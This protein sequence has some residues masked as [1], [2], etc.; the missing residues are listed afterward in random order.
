[1]KA[2]R[3]LG[4]AC[5]CATL[6]AA[7]PPHTTIYGFT[8]ITSDKEFALEDRFLDIPTAS[9]AL[10][11]AAVLASRPHYAG[12]DGDYKLAYFVRDTFKDYGIEATVESFTAR[13]DT[14]KKLALEI[15]PPGIVG[16][17][18]PAK[19]TV[20]AYTPIFKRRQ[21]RDTANL[22][23]PRFATAP[24]AGLDL[25]ELP[26]PNDPDT[27]NPAVGLPF[28]AGSGDGDVTGPLVYAGHGLPADY[29]LLTAH[30]IDVTG[31]VVLV[32]FGAEF[33]G[34]IVR[35][36]QNH[37]VHAV[38][39]YDDP[40]DDGPGRGGAYPNGPWRP[41]NSVQRGSL[42]L[43]ITVPV[44]PIS[45]NNARLLLASI[46]GPSAPAP[47]TGRLPV[48]YPFAKGPANVR[49]VVELNHRT[50]TLWNTIGVIHGTTPGQQL[51][52]GAHRDAWVYGLGSG[53]GGVI[54]LLETARGL[55][56][57]ALTGWQPGR[58]IVLAAWD[59][60]E[61][62][63]FGSLA[64][65]KRH[66]DELN[67]GS[68]AY[69]NTEPSVT[70]TTFGADAVAAIAPTIAEASHVAPDPAFPG[71]TIYERWAFR[72]HGVL[73]PV[74]R[75]PG[76]GDRDA[77][78]FNAGTPSA[79]ASFTGP[80]GPYHSSY[81]TLLYARTI[82]DPEFA[83]HRAAAQIYGVAALRLANADVVPYH[84]TAYV[85]PMH[86]AVRS[87]AA[88]ARLR[89]VNFDAR[90][91]ERSIGGFA[92]SAARSDLATTR[93]SAAQVPE[94]QLE[95][96]RIIDLAAYGIEGDSQISFPDVEHAVR[97]GDQAG[98]DLAIARA[99]TT[100]DRASNLIH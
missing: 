83:L 66:G 71:N 3:V 31:S 64:Y 60:E 30:G 25:R 49:V 43:G 26:D 79:N 92:A 73:P 65:I 52:I 85:A 69:L 12:S 28:L 75:P 45:A 62:G 22:A 82:S 93:V 2:L 44:L 10:E 27:Q 88:L 33:R 8:T 74:T 80:F 96:A 55:G 17:A 95:A 41:L 84:F 6:L 42:G 54:T 21:K 86:S 14:P 57:L 61:L 9:G 48:G 29:A 76:G 35:R 56:N 87:L 32:R 15:Y 5:A 78:L 72:T 38:I 47:W 50:T 36:A 89:N 18:P 77:F 99:R 68:I 1:M 100:I 63:Q 90:G 4:V 11:N 7:A 24:M 98:V 94:N 34:A 59:G 40:A 13:I 51:V 67:T 19:I 70:G 46:H 37:G 53:G 20:P 81:D 16:M 97:A 91:F 23:A 58:T 39:M